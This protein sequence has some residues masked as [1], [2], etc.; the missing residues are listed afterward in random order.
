[1]GDLRG[2]HAASE[3]GEV[4]CSGVSAAATALKWLKAVFKVVAIRLQS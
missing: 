2:L 4:H 1:M 3:P